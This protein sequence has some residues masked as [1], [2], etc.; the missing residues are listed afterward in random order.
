MALVGKSASLR[1]LCQRQIGSVDEFARADEALRKTPP[2]RGL[3]ESLSESPLELTARQATRG[4]NLGYADVGGEVVE[5]H[6]FGP[7]LLPSSKAAAPPAL[8]QSQ[9]AISN[10]KMEPCG[11]K[12]IIGK[13]RRRFM[14]VLEKRQ[15]CIDK[16][17][18]VGVEA[19]FARKWTAQ[20]LDPAPTIFVGEFVK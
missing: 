17:K 8:R 16:A 19:G 7:S 2:V 9:A 3:P 14:G 18:R 12:N 1:Y 6:L 13:K 15:H 10:G 11:A 5:H 4:R 20:P